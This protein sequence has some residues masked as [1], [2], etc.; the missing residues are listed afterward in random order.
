MRNTTV[1]LIP[2]KLALDLFCKGAEWS[3]GDWM[4]S[5]FCFGYEFI[6]VYT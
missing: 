5:L 4:K 3:V 2:R 6:L 1:C